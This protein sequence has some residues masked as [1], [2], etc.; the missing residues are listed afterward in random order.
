MIILCKIVA[1]VRLESLSLAGLEEGTFH[2]TKNF[3][4]PLVAERDR[5]LI[6]LLAIYSVIPG[7][8]DFPDT[9]DC[10]H[11]ECT[12]SPWKWAE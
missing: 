9:R 1:P 4:W 12:G 6:C 11:C 2:K 5:S 7:T 10:G 3:K 8:P